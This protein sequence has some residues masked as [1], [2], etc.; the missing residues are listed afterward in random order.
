MLRFLAPV[1]EGSDSSANGV[2]VELAKDGV[3]VEAEHGVVGVDVAVKERITYV[4][5][6][7]LLLAW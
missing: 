4:V 5:E 7:V 1:L 6:L 3:A 2:D